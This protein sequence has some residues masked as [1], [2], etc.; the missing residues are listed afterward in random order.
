MAS[1]THCRGASQVH[2]ADEPRGLLKLG[3]DSVP[4][5]RDDAA[6]RAALPASGLDDVRSAFQGQATH[7]TLIHASP[8]STAST[9]PMNTHCVR[10]G[11]PFVVAKGMLTTNAISH[12]FAIS[13]S[14]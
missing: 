14:A 2:Q 10:I 8:S 13:A 11:Q 9:P 7:P 6:T 1:T 12:P 4:A 3:A 5:L